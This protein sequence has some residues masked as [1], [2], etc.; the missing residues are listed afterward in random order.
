MMSTIIGHHTAIVEKE[1]NKAIA[2]QIT[3]CLLR[4]DELG[5]R[6]YRRAM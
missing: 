4:L 3:F 2:V 5:V 6:L 1:I